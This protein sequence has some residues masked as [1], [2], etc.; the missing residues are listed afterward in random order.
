MMKKTFVFQKPL[1]LFLVIFL[2]TLLSCNLPIARN[3]SVGGENTEKF[4][5]G[6]AVTVFSGIV[7]S[8]G[9]RIEI[10]QT[11]DPLL[12]MV[13]EIPAEAF[14]ED[15]EI[16]I[17]RLS[18]NETPYGENFIPLTP[19]I[20]VHLSRDQP[21]RYLAFKIPVQV[22]DGY[23]AVPFRVDLPT[24]EPEALIVTDQDEKSISF[25]TDHF[26]DFIVA[27]VKETALMGDFDTSF[28]QGRDNFRFPNAGSIITENGE[29]A[30]QSLA[31]LY[32]ND[33]KT[34][35]ALFDSFDG[36]NGILGA[37]PDFW[38]DDVMVYK[39]SALAHLE[40]RHGSPSTLNF[41]VSLQKD[42]HFRTYL[43]LSYLMLLTEKPQLIAVTNENSGHALVVYQKKGTDLLVSD[44]NFPFQQNR[45]IHF[46]L[47]NQVFHPYQTPS[48]QNGVNIQYSNFF[49]LPKRDAISWPILENLWNQVLDGEF[50]GDPFPKISLKII[51]YDDLGNFLPAVDL[52]QNYQTK[53]VFVDIFHSPLSFP[54]RLSVFSYGASE[55][56]EFVESSELSNPIRLYLY[57]GDNYYG[58]LLEKRTETNEYVWAGF[59]WVNIIRTENPE[60]NNQRSDESE[61]LN[62]QECV[63][64]PYLQF[65]YEDPEVLTLQNTDCSYICS[66]DLYVSHE[67]AEPVTLFYLYLEEDRVNPTKERWF[68]LKIQP[69]S[70]GRLFFYNVGINNANCAWA[71]KTVLRI[72]AILNDDRC[73]WIMKDIGYDLQ[74]IGEVDLQWIEP[75]NPCP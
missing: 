42:Q 11:D 69:D 6:Q 59:E 10:N 70:S 24:G 31:S 75:T 33:Q 65:S 46:D 71:K 23:F 8:E 21:Q 43:T 64:T 32:F 1:I 54:A 14:M 63:M 39:L 4:S 29:C 3:Q 48:K 66:S 50:V 40:Y 61:P 56:V 49:Y 13:L 9:G 62:L 28:I 22:P 52:L 51:D 45:S 68:D 41:W 60:L 5:L 7:G 57:P 72:G 55:R 18:V 73:Q 35:E 67:I 2:F 74:R 19:L 37:T 12:G 26:S 20:R 44:P 36:Y 15:T 38:Q 27:M 25:I 17:S 30:G 58:F 16:D 47:Q 53:N 34:G